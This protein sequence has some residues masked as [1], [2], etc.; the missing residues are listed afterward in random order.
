MADE[1]EAAAL[2]NERNEPARRGADAPAEAGQ[3]MNA[4]LPKCDTVFHDRTDAAP[5]LSWRAD[6]RAE[7]HERLVELGTGA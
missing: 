7:F 3:L 1:E 6:E 5:G 4:A 2:R